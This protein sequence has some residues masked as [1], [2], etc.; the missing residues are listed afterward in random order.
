MTRVRTALVTGATRGIGLEVA[1]V[2]I[3]DGV[4]VVM[5]ARSEAD[6][7]ARA[8]ELG[9]LAVPIVCDVSNADAVARAAE[10]A[11]P[12]SVEHRRRS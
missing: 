1:R 9:E 6:L 12:T 2:L 8:R 11:P 10:R 5:L 3:G 4:R 7:H